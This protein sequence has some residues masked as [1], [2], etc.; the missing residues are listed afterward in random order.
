MYTDMDS[1]AHDTA[2]KDQMFVV[3]VSVAV[4]GL[5]VVFIRAVQ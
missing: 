2:E 1:V 5:T 4:D 3:G